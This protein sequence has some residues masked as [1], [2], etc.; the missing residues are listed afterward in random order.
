M[1]ELHLYDHTDNFLRRMGYAEVYCEDY[2]VTAG[3]C[4]QD[5][6]GILHAEVASIGDVISWIR[7]IGRQVR[8]IHTLKFHTHGSIGRI[9]LPNGSITAANVNALRPVCSEFLSMPADVQ[10]YGCNVAEGPNGRATL[11]TAGVTAPLRDGRPIRARSGVATPDLASRSTGARQPYATANR[12]LRAG[13][14]AIHSL[15]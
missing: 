10:F 5:R 4:L 8:T 14:D 3:R 15:R 11:M 13:G 7:T 2:S 9:S 6:P 1:T 12:Q